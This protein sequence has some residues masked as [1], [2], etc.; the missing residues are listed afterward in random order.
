MRR[1]VVHAGDL[2]T[3]VALGGGALARTV[4]DQ[5]RH[6]H[7]RTQGREMLDVVRMEGDRDARHA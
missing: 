1:H 3:R 4:A 5:H 7:Q 2:Q 6:A